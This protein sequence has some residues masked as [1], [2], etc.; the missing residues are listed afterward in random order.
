MNMSIIISTAPQGFSFNLSFVLILLALIAITLYVLRFLGMLNPGNNQKYSAKN[1]QRIKSSSLEGKNFIF[2]GSSVTKGFEARGES[3]VEMIAVR[4]GTHYVKEAVTGTTLIDKNKKSYISRLKLLDKNTPCDIFV[5]QL[6]T[7]DAT[8][9]APIGEIGNSYDDNFDT[10]TVAGAIEYVISY[11][12]KTWSCPI[13]FYTNPQYDSPA[14]QAMVEVLLDIAKKW[15]VGVIDLWHNKE[16]NEMSNEKSN[17]FM[18][19]GIHPT[20]KGYLEWTPIFE[21][22]LAEVLSGREITSES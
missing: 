14:Y 22:A 13:V 2:L 20:K 16:I 7:N 17:H 3:F 15:N 9:K 12:K 1:M 10:M 5:C 21:K 8:F 4:N 11:V 19:D 18:N 6:S